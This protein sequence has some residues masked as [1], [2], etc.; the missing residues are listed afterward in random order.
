MPCVLLGSN[1]NNSA[2]CRSRY[3]NW[4][5]SPLNLNSNISLRRYADT[6][7]NIASAANPWLGARALL[8]SKIQN[9]G[10]CVASSES[11]RHANY[12]FEKTWQLI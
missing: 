5:N 3:S 9:W 1:W 11:E 2:N 7:W 12:L 10:G 6:G 8:K 4:N